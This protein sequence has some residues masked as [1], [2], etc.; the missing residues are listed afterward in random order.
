MPWR[1]PACSIQIRHSDAEIAPRVGAR[2]R[3]YACRLELALDAKTN[4]L[5][6]PPLDVPANTRRA[7]K[8]PLTK[9]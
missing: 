7:Q 1:C 6:V 4:R 8:A 3:C 5:V 9:R 2:Y